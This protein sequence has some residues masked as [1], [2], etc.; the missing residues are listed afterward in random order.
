LRHRYTD[1]VIISIEARQSLHQRL[2]SLPLRLAILAA[3]FL[4]EKIL[5]HFL[6][7]TNGA[8]TAHGLA[9]LVRDV[10]SQAFHLLG[11]GFVCLVL[12]SYVR[13][14]KTGARIFEPRAA[15]DIRVPWLI[16]HALL[17]LPLAP[18]AFF[19][20]RDPG[21][22]PRFVALAA[23]SVLLIAAAVLAAF[24]AMA[25]WSTWRD[26][27][28]RLGALWIYAALVAAMAT[29]ALPWVQKLWPSAAALTFELVRFLLQPFLPLLS[30]DP[31]K[32]ILSTNR[33]SV[34]ISEGCSGLEGLGLM[35]AF[36]SGWLLLFR[37][38][39]RFPRALVLVPIGLLLVF[40]L[41]AV[42]IAA[43]VLIGHAGYPDVAEY[44]FHTQAGWIGF[45]C[46]AGAVVLFSR[47]SRWM[48]RSAYSGDARGDNPTAAYLMP[49]L[50]M[51]AAGILA[52]AM[53]GGFD[54]LYSLRL[55]AGVAALAYYRSRLTGLDWRFSWRGP[56]TGVAIFVVWMLAARIWLTPSALPQSLS[57]FS[58]MLR[59][60]WITSRALT[61]IAI[62]PIAE[63]LA[64]RGYLLRRLIGADFESVPFAAVHLPA[65]GL[66][67]VLFGVNHGVMWAPGIVA[68]WLYGRLVCRTGRIG[69]S[70]AAHATT[71][72]LLAGLVIFS[73]Q[74]QF[75]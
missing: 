11:T 57:S 61:A 49:F 66:T 53:S 68:G 27:A 31:S 21:D 65:L 40:A 45:T 5:L 73:D 26:A 32:L 15:E 52:L 69:E 35:L 33:F 9:A 13:S 56:I 62:V 38:E 12:F 23:L 39:Y 37:T 42:R 75:W 64:Y 10:Q 19:L 60:G 2:Q 67:S 17:V 50:A 74:W 1:R 16:A 7:D 4:L 48:N 36:C 44:G 28:R 71:N 72:G 34:E 58:P 8:E 25:P 14:G 43:L 18:L 20:Y 70:V 29:L 54:A 3:I 55:V 24:W 59:F 22:E 51:Q 30:A 47:R 41:N 46:A 63:E 6:I